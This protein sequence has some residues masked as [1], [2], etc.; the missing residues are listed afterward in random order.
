[1][2]LTQEDK[3]KIVELRE[4]GLGYEIIAKQFNVKQQ[5]GKEFTNFHIL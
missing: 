1:M 3:I 2:K 4:Q 5:I